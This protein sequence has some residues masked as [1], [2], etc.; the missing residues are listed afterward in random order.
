[1]NQEV[2]S[3]LI[4]HLNDGTLKLGHAPEAIKEWLKGL[5]LPL[6]LYQFMM[7]RWPQAD[8]RIGGV[9]ILCSQAIPE[10]EDMDETGAFNAFLRAEATHEAFPPYAPRQAEQV[11]QRARAQH[12]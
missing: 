3:S 6:D 2:A 7:F 1:M 4:Y 11:K 8:G 5:G 10:H 12:D 9:D